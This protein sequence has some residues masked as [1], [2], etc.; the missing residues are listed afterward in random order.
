MRSRSWQLADLS[1]TLLALGTLAL[2]QSAT[3]FSGNDWFIEAS[4]VQSGLPNRSPSC[5][6]I[7]T[8]RSWAVPSRKTG[9]SSFS[10]LKE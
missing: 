8:E 4:Q 1:I 3:T 10:V 2:A 7:R 6:A 5:S 9:C